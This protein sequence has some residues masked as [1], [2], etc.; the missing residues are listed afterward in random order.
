[1]TFPVRKLLH[2]FFSLFLFLSLAIPV[3]A[4]QDSKAVIYFFWG[5]GCPHC[6]REEVFLNELAK[7]YSNLEIKSFE[8]THSREN[9]EIAEEFRKKL[10]IKNPGIP[11]AIIEDKYFIGYLSD[12]TTGKEIEAIVK[13]SLGISDQEKLALNRINL[14]FLGEVNIKDFSLPLL[15]VALGFLDGFNPCAM[16]TLVFLISLLLGM[17]DRK[18]MWILGS[19]FIVAS[20]FVYFIIMA[21]WL[22]LF[23]FLGFIVWIRIIIGLVALGTGGYNIREFFINKQGACKVTG[24]KKRKAVFDKLRQIT[25]KKE[26]FLALIG[27]ILLAFAVNMVELVCSAGL[28]AVF[29]QI[30]VINN[31]PKLQYYLYLLLYIFFFMID[32]L[33]IFFVAM[34]TL[35]M[36]G[37]EGKYA[38]YSRL[39]GGLMMLVIGILMLFK[40]EFLMLG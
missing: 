26:F 22:N 27:I 35:K 4:N 2:C 32:D 10:N 21:A 9:I 5:Q 14:P 12:E 3:F 7:K 31:L 37:I 19:A 1:M 6:A 8:T 38:R 20:A 24:S 39:I 28:P 25:Q 30:L 23:L 18:R 40:P 13:K 34:T 11:L 15:S 33:F 16:W 29:T 17:R 36:F